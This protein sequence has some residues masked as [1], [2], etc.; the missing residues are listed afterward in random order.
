MSVSES[1]SEQT[2]LR[3][4]SPQV[5]QGEQINS[6]QWRFFFSYLAVSAAALLFFSSLYALFPDLRSALIRE[7]DV[8]ENLT[9]LFFAEGLLAVLII[10]FVKQRLTRG[11][12][13]LGG[14]CL[15]ACLEE[16]SYGQRFLPF[17]FPT[18]PN[19]ATFDALSDL[20]RVVTLSFDALGLP[21]EPF[22][23]AAAALITF[24]YRRPLF[25]FVKANTR[26]DSIW[27]YVLF[28]AGFIALSTL[29][30]SYINPPDTFVL[31]EELA[32]MSA[33]L[34][35]L[36]AAFSRLIVQRTDPAHYENQDVRSA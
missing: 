24:I 8:L 33:A 18:L 7:N 14:L 20:N 12:L 10:S 15:L 26:P 34:S 3:P 13:I 9:L 35:L 4:H 19:G 5:S 28:A 16:L 22:V 25:R 1:V 30:D 21:W 29:I 32:E 31:V 17:A 27:F 11:Y 2:T 23:L 36:F 6:A